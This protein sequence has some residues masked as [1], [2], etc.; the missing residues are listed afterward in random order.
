MSP[1]TNTEKT[2]DKFKKIEMGLKCIRDLNLLDDFFDETW[3]EGT[4]KFLD[5]Y[6]DKKSF[7][8]I[9]L[10]ETD[11]VIEQVTEWFGDDYGLAVIDG[12]FW[13]VSVGSVEEGG[14]KW[15][16]KMKLNTDDIETARQVILLDKCRPRRY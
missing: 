11:K 6:E 1:D 13:M 10:E 14:N 16:F 4:E 15:W 5:K 12:E 3:K 7:Y 2:K 8:D 9:S